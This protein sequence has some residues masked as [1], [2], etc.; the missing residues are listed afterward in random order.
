T[1]G[2]AAAP[3]ELPD[4]GAATPLQGGYGQLDPVR[5][6]QFEL[7][8]GMQGPDVMAL[9]MALQMAGYPV[10][11]TGTFD[12][13]TEA[14]M[15]LFQMDAGQ[16]ASGVCGRAGALALDRRFGV[17]GRPGALGAPA[18]VDPMRVAQGVE[19]LHRAMAGLGT[20]EAAI[21]DV[22]EN[23]PPAEV[24][25]IAQQFAQRYGMQWGSL[26]Q[27]LVSEMSGLELNRALG[28][29]N[30]AFA[31][32]FGGPGAVAAP[33]PNARFAFA[34]NAAYALHRA[35]A[36]LGTDE[37]T[38]YRILGSLSPSDMVLVEGA[39]RRNFGWQW[40][41]L[42][43]ALVSEFSAFELMRALQLH[44]GKLAAAYR[45]WR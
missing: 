32:T 23:R 15:M 3:I 11:T 25:A 12:T 38:V 40:G 27:A 37:Q 19:Q 44:D 10:E 4:P 18:A 1:K 17:P 43:Q 42:R 8:R 45:G 9:Q 30:R 13:R 34:Q 28:A 7:L 36:G 26:G 20:D 2:A 22:L 21:Y 33:T 31:T 39:F 35:M 41:S 16:P 5:Q 29:L 14:A 24:V 6:G